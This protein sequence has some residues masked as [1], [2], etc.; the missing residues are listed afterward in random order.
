VIEDNLGGAAFVVESLQ[1]EICR[2]QKRIH[3]KGSKHGGQR[4][5]KEGN[6]Y[7]RP[8]FHFVAQLMIHQDA[9]TLLQRWRVARN[10]FRINFG[11]VKEKG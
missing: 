8:S 6:C 11:V 10:I 4:W 3:R 7:S 5:R 1:I 9:Q 2:T